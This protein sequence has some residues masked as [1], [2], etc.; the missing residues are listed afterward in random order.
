MNGPQHFREAEGFL[1]SAAYW[2]EEEDLPSVQVDYALR[3]ALV[4]ATLAH[5]AAVAELDP[6]GH[7]EGTGRTVE[8]SEAWKKV[9][10][11]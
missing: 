5:A 9:L 11:S 8:R 2:K 3:R 10:D 6:F 4:H 7:E 1:E